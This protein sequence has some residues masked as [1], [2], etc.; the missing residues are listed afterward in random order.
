[1]ASNEEENKKFGQ[2][3]HSK[4]NTTANWTDWNLCLNDKL[5]KPPKPQNPPQKPPK[6]PQK[7]PQKPPKPPKSIIESIQ[8]LQACPI[9]PPKLQQLKTDTL[10]TKIV[11]SP[12]HLTQDD[13]SSKKDAVPTVA[14]FKSPQPVE[15]ATRPQHMPGGGKFINSNITSNFI[16]NLKHQKEYTT[17]DDIIYQNK[18]LKYKYLY[19]KNK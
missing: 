11:Q 10:S 8:K 4:R 9:K 16:Q 17:T 15:P 1:M 2:T 6:P 5:K 13:E 7:P 18:Y 3:L 12:E 14:E 19:L